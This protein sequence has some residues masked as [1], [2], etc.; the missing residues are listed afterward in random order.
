M[1]KKT[2]TAYVHQLKRATF[3]R[4]LDLCIFGRSAGTEAGRL[5][6][7]VIACDGLQKDVEKYAQ[8]RHGG[9]PETI[10]ARLERLAKL[11]EPMF[12]YRYKGIDALLMQ[13]RCVREGLEGYLAELS[14][15]AILNGETQWFSGLAEAVEL[16]H[17][18]GC[19][20]FD[21]HRWCILNLLFTT[22]GHEA[23]AKL[24]PQT[25][26]LL[27]LTLRDVTQHLQREFSELTDTG[28]LPRQIRR[29]CSEIGIKLAKGKPGRR[30]GSRNR[31]DGK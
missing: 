7:D 17:R 6:W 15:S 3:A 4:R 30:R 14:I 13:A 8:P 11:Y 18:N 1:A 28:D 9:L 26:A 20:P 19:K 22:I 29:W 27:P 5:V 12:L 23:S 21:P 31:W 24:G 2:G 25:T 16:W 10:K